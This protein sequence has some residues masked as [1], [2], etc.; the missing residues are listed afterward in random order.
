MKIMKLFGVIGRSQVMLNLNPK[1][2]TGQPINY[3]FRNTDLI[4]YL[5][6]AD[7]EESIKINL[8]TQSV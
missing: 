1:K 6:K 2:D 4:K 3:I 7:Y 5:E 8:D